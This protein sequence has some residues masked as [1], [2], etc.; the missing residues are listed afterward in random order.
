MKERQA[1]KEPGALPL[2]EYRRR[3]CE[4]ESIASFTVMD[5]YAVIIDDEPDDSLGRTS[6]LGLREEPWLAS[7]TQGEREGGRKDDGASGRPRFLIC[8]V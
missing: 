7:K 2:R 5:G 8:L 6:P 4:V 3:D 1:Q